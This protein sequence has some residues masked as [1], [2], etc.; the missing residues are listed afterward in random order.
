MT[1]AEGATARGGR[2]QHLTLTRHA[3]HVRIGDRSRGPGF[4]HL[5]GLG[6]AT[7]VTHAGDLIR[8]TD[9]THVIHI[10]AIGCATRV[11]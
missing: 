7:G 5:R 10:H 4:T 9:T 6:R 1:R 2:P 11:R 8:D 3:P